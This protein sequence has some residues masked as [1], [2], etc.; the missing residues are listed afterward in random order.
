M[1]TDTELEQMFAEL[2][3]PAAGR[4]LIRRMRSKGPVRELQYRMT[5]VRTRLVSKKMGGRALYAESRTCEF[6]AIYIREQDHITQELWPQPITIDLT[7]E[8]R[9]GSTRVQ[10]TP[11]LFAIEPDRFIV[12]EWRELPRL[13][14]LAEERPHS[15]Y[16]DED[17]KWHYIQAEEHF[18]A[19]G[20]EYRLCCSDE[21]PRVL[22]SNLMFLE[23]YALES[24]P[25]VSDEVRA[26]LTAVLSEHKRL[27]HLQLVVE[28]GFAADHIFQLILDGVA[29]V[30]LHET[31]VRETGQL[32]IY[33][34]ETI[35]R[36]DAVLNRDPEA[37]LPSSA[38]VISS[39][40]RF[41]FDGVRYEVVLPGRTQITVL[42]LETNKNSVLPMALVQELF[43]KQYLGPAAAQKAEKGTCT[44]AILNAKSLGD[45]LDRLD[46]LH[47][48]EA[49]GV[50]DR[51]LRRWRERTKGLNSPQEQL[52]ALMTRN[53]GNTTSRL[54]ADAVKLAEKVLEEWHNTAKCPTKQSSYN[55]Y[56]TLCSS[57]DTKP[58]SRS[59]FYK[60]IDRHE[61]VAARKGKRKAYQDAPIP[62]TYDF[63]HPVHGV[64]PHEICYCD[65]TILNI[66]LKGSAV[67]DL[68]KPTIT[69]MVDGS[70]SKARA[71][72]LSY[73]PASSTSV[74][75]C[76]R[77]YVRR[78]NRL[79]KILVLD[80]GKEFHS[81]ALLLF[82]SLFGITI[83]WRRASH[84]RD[85][86]IVERMLG[87]TEKE[88]IQQLDGN[89]IA[90]K[91]PRM[92]SSTHHPDK[93]IRWTLPALHGVFEY[94]LFDVHCKRI[95][96]RFGMSPDDQEKRQLLEYGSRSHVVVRYDQTLKLL[97]APHCGPATRVIDRKR[98]VYADGMWYWHDRLAL[99]EKGEECEV[100]TELWR[101]RILY[102]CFRGNWYVAQARDGGRLE[103]RY[104]QEFELQLRE[105]NRARKTDAQRDKNSVENSQK[106]ERLWRDP[107]EWDERLRDQL[108]EA[109][110]LYEKLGMAEVLPEAK[111]PMGGIVDISTGKGSELDMLYAVQGEPGV[112]VAREIE[113]AEVEANAIAGGNTKPKK[114]KPKAEPA[115]P[116][117]PNS[118]PS[119][120]QQPVRTAVAPAAVTDDDYF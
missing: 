7:I 78:N 93:H 60:W 101:M 112:Y 43:N 48:P 46:A 62:L 79:P 9:K 106:R 49:A 13:M 116:A 29:Y 113:P 120:L 74:L 115:A 57:G 25:V 11:D 81:H 24:T 3:T 17:G 92:V 64:L 5:G 84:P 102:V 56:V 16:R 110:Y 89:S 61:N 83:R 44:D 70:L 45:A 69:L 99:A 68:G 108:S 87:V 39:G 47:N 73:S 103:G 104:R 55:T 107:A 42:N 59:A 22:L 20:I 18:K 38:L 28:H 35:A 97:T 2:K 80:N 66:F 32:I 41:L 86:T 53:P 98:G 96:P 52:D 63:K 82:C 88:I 117:G 10:H 12:E 6:P 58:M 14:R 31:L 26:R 75:M 27:P 111:N 21:H 91:D 109:Y 51:T 85:S 100:R 8:G 71:F 37:A 15:F 50:T 36:A 40:Q 90:M 23:D 65:H 105:E 33:R 77:D 67:E 19:L 30:D 4:E 94:F 54:P 76:L 114:V 118:H 119:S 1:L 72:Y 34:D 95:H